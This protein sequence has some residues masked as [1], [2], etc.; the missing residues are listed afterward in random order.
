[1]LV[2][3]RLGLVGTP[4]N[5]L[6]L[7]SRWRLPGMV[8]M[9]SALMLF[10]DASWTVGSYLFISVNHCIGFVSIRNASLVRLSVWRMRLLTKI[11]ALNRLA[12]V[13]VLV[14]IVLGSWSRWKRLLI[15]RRKPLEK[16]V[17]LLIG[18]SRVFHHKN[19]LKYRLLTIKYL[20]DV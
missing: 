10:R 7:L 6:L 17:M 4:L 14:K 9:L 12:V 13:R 19:G 15:G 20:K 18:L 16:H 2:V 3:W 11:T 5:C 8:T 1:M